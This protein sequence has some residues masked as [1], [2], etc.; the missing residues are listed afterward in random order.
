M[1]NAPKGQA[2]KG[3]TPAAKSPTGKRTSTSPN[4]TEIDTTGMSPEQIA[5]LAEHSIA[6][7][8]TKPRNKVPAK[9]QKGTGNTAK[10]P[11]TVKSEGEGA[12]KSKG[13]RPSSFTQEIA[14][15]ICE[16]LAEG[17]SLRSLCKADNMPNAGTVCR[18]LATNE[19]FREQ[20]ARAREAQAETLFDEMLDI[21]DDGRND[22]YEDENGNVRTDHDVIARSKLRVE[23]RKWMAGKLKPK[24][25]GDKI[26]LNHGVQPEN[27]LA[28]L[29]AQVS[30]TALPVVKDADEE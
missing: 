3:N 10:H 30:G 16:G 5:A 12:E 9:N 13:G 8:K 14:D 11:K 20:Y 21:A 17:H 23:T 27:P 18:W 1:A 25:Y 29:L 2:Q 22:K 7:R 4:W 15:L 28:A 19:T 6:Q 24:V 26:D